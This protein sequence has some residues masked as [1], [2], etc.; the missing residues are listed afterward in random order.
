MLKIW[1][2]TTSFAA[3]DPMDTECLIEEED[4]CFAWCFAC[5]PSR[6]AN[7]S[8]SETILYEN[9]WDSLVQDVDGC[10]K[11]AIMKS[12]AFLITLFSDMREEESN[13]NCKIDLESEEQRTRWSTLFNALHKT[14]IYPSWK[15]H[16]VS[17]RERILLYKKVM[18]N[19]WERTKILVE[20]A[21]MV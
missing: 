15:I 9:H 10:A 2:H 18:S 11:F 13:V 5:N 21:E 3:F 4:T 19:S 16:F 12:S 1:E 6:R 14:G 20:N 17:G 7:I 8:N